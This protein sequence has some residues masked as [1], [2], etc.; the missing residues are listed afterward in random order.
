MKNDPLCIKEDVC[1]MAVCNGAMHCSHAVRKSAVLAQQT[2]NVRAIMKL[3]N[4]VRLLLLDVDT[5]TREQRSD[6]VHR[7]AQLS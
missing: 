2:T 4:D 3:L 5:P 7:I 6:I 1:D